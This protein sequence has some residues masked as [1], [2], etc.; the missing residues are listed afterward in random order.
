M[1][2]PSRC[3]GSKPQLVINRAA[4]SSP[5]AFLSWELEANVGIWEFWDPGSLLYV[6]LTNLGSSF[7]LISLNDP[8]LPTGWSPD[9]LL[10][11]IR[12]FILWF[13]LAFSWHCPNAPCSPL[14]SSF[15]RKTCSFL[16]LHVFH[17][18]Y[19]YPGML[20]A[21]LFS[22]IPH[23]PHSPWALPLTTW[24]ASFKTQLIFHLLCETF[25]KP[26]RQDWA[27]VFIT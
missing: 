19:P 11:P 4:W 8:W 20:I 5:S 14:I 22:H 13:Q 1:Q 24:W 21:P 3:L 23:L 10:Q 26:I 15:L 9:I 6:I 2:W 17:I 7:C 18:L 25:F 27:H 16:V 12:P